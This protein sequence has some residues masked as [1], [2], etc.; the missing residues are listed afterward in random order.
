MTT[1]FK[2]DGKSTPNK[3]N[4]PPFI[5]RGPARIP[6]SAILQIFPIDNCYRIQVTDLNAIPI[7]ICKDTKED[8]DR[9]TQMFYS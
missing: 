2:D 1:L 4:S 6:T 8:Y 3:I 7:N 9:I 5:T